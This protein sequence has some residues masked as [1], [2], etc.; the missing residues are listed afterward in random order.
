VVFSPNDPFFDRQWKGMSSGKKPYTFLDV[1][2]DRLWGGALPWK[3]GQ[4]TA[5]RDTIEGQE[6]KTLQPGEQL[7]TFVCTN[8]DDHVAKLLARYHG[9]FLWR[10]QVRRGLV[11]VG[12]R[13]YPASAVI[14]VHFKDTDIRPAT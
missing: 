6:Y 11:Q 7:T 9:P 8:P 10:I 1:G 14:G 12:D 4:P 3:P 5:E 13:E 2:N